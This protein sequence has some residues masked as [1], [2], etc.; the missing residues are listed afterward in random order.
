MELRGL[1]SH[2]ADS[3]HILAKSFKF[4]IENDMRS[5][6]K[7][8]RCKQSTYEIL[9]DNE[10]Q[11]CALAFSA[12]QGR[13]VSLLPGVSATLPLTPFP[14][15]LPPASLISSR[16]FGHP[17]YA[18]VIAGACSVCQRSPERGEP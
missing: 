14:L 15:T 2:P 3:R 11:Y 16:E 6:E 8:C 18:G 10:N 9:I 4:L 1:T 5:R 12:F 7:S 17:A 13:S